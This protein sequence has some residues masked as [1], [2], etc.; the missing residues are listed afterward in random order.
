[1]D[2]CAELAKAFVLYC[3]SFLEDCATLTPTFG[4]NL[5]SIP[6]SVGFLT[7][8]AVPWYLIKGAISLVY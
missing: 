7:T 8:L 6:V 4:S 1:M 5:L 3:A 2:A